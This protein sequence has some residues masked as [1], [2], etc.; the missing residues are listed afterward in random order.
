[1]ALKKHYAL[2]AYYLQRCYEV[3]KLSKEYKAEMN[4][5]FLENLNN[6]WI[7]DLYNY[8]TT[9]LKK[10]LKYLKRKKYWSP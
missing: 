8:Y 4:I 2:A 6:E 10:Y 1:M 9:A 3:E 7:E 5:F